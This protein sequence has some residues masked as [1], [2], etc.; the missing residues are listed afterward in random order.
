MFSRWNCYDSFPVQPLASAPPIVYSGYNMYESAGWVGYCLDG[1]LGNHHVTLR[2]C[3]KGDTHQHWIERSHPIVS[4]AIFE[5][6]LNAECLDGSLA[7][8]YL[9]PCCVHD[10]HQWWAGDAEA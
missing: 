6:Q 10:E 4:A 9:Q 5:D 8:V 7:D 2:P 1:A 3:N